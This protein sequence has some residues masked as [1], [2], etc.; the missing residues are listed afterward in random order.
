MFAF[1]NR[2]QRLRSTAAGEFLV[3]TPCIIVS[4]RA[5]KKKKRHIDVIVIILAIARP[6]RTNLL[7]R[8]RDEAFLQTP[9]P[10]KVVTHA[11][12]S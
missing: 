8:K 7:G 3:P 2:D 9:L 4:S 1:N 12:S 10:V 5:Q 11:H 6:D